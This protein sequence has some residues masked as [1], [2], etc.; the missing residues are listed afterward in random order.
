ML[1]W[2]TS[3]AKSAIVLP[4]EFSRRERIDDYPD[5]SSHRTIRRAQS[6]RV[7][8]HPSRPALLLTLPR[9]SPHGST[10]VGLGTPQRTRKRG[11]KQDFGLIVGECTTPFSGTSAPRSGRGQV[12]KRRPAR[13]RAR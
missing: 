10:G 11:W 9:K 1:T 3:F 5:R 8:S 7:G 4:I 2:R 12:T 6:A 13:S